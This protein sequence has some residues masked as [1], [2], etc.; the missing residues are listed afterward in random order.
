MVFKYKSELPN[1]WVDYDFNQPDRIIRNALS[2]MW[3][4]LPNERRSITNVKDDFNKLVDRVLNDART[5]LG[6][7]NSE[8]KQ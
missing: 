2:L 4:M 8:N 1:D 7:Q 3:C 6:I 5:D